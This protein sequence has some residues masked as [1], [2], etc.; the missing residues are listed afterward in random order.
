M[1][2]LE[3]ARAEAAEYVP[4]YVRA[5]SDGTFSVVHSES[6]DAFDVEHASAKAALAIALEYETV[7][8]CV[9]RANL[10]EDGEPIGAWRWLDATA[11]EDES[12]GGCR[13]TASSIWEMCAALNARKSAIP[14]NGG[15][16][17]REDLGSSEPHGDAYTGGDHLANGYAH[18]ALPVIDA[19]GRTHL[20]LWCELLPA[21]VKEVDLGRLAY[22]SIRFGFTAVDEDDDYAISGASLIS[23]ALTNDPAVT[24]LTAGS[25]RRRGSEPAFVACRTR[26]SIMAKKIDHA[27]R[28][29]DPKLTA[30]ARVR[31]A[32]AAIEETGE[33]GPM[34]DLLGK[35]AGMVGVSSADLC[36][37]SFALS[38]AIYALQSAAKFEKVLEAAAPPPAPAPADAAASA[39]DRAVRQEPDEQQQQYDAFL[40]WGREVTGKPEASFAEVL[41]ELDA[42]KEEAG[43]IFGQDVPPKKDEPEGEPAAGSE[44]EE[45]AEGDKIEDEEDDEEEEKQAEKSRSDAR[46]WLDVEL[47]S[48]HLTVDDAARAELETDAVASRAAVKRELALRERVQRFET[49]TWLDEEISKRENS[50]KNKTLG[51]GP[52]DR[53]DLV[54]VAIAAGRELVVK[55]LNARNA[56][57][58]ANVLD[59][60]SAPIATVHPASQTAAYDACMD[61]AQRELDEAEAARAKRERRKPLAVDRHVV[62]AQAQKIAAQRFPEL[63]GANTAR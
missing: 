7:A 38:D 46:A 23:H 11:E 20:F 60:R 59:G 62:R 5:E 61:D 13:I 40:A 50:A 41:A 15:G 31:H 37:G 49:R 34:S 8:A 28:A 39:S 55:T 4:F 63:F 14:V 44:E 35:V 19:E 29:R 48:R 33:R 3:D 52:Q 45:P 2:T 54:D 57:P 51:I 1:P 36:S 26:K 42:R 58:G 9:K 53:E 25:E 24:T 12:I 43:K 32:L 22:G 47:R 18:I 17:P 30:D 6:D 16:K 21:I 27:A 10:R 56:P